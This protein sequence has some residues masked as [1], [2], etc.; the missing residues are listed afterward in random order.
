LPQV[1]GTPA[2]DNESEFPDQGLQGLNR[3]DHL[4]R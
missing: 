3:H 1:L 4:H 2:A